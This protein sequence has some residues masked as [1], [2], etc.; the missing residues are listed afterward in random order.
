MSDR[1]KKTL[2]ALVRRRA[3]SPA[4]AIDSNRAAMSY[5]DDIDLTGAD[6]ADL[7]DEL[8]LWSAPF[9]ALL[10]EKVPVRRGMTVLHSHIQHRGTIDSVNA[11]LNRAGFESL[12]ATTGAFTMRFADGSAL[13]R[14]Y[15]I[16]LA[17][18][19]GWKSIVPDPLGGRTFM[20]LKCRV[21]RA[22]IIRQSS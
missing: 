2:L 17:F 6:T 11:M 8:P 13:F 18:M 15:F 3:D 10:L 21:I 20:A 12:G 22:A 4:G 5:L 14:H 7:H 1:H 19:P 16:R 9:G